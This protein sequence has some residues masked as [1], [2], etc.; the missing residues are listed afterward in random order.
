MKEA[1]QKAIEGGWR[2]NHQIQMIDNFHYKDGYLQINRGS[3][4]FLD[5]LFWISLG[6]S[7][8]WGKCLNCGDPGNSAHHF[9]PS[10][11]CEVCGGTQPGEYMFH[12]HRFIDFLAA[13]KDKEDIDVFFNDLLK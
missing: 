6:K 13:V 5:P 12:W 8:G 10:G 3:H 11:Q 2:P 1:I 4:I 9:T 7:L